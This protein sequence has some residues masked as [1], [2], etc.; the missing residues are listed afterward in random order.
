MKRYVKLIISCILAVVLM[1]NLTACTGFFTNPISL[2]QPPKLSGNLV[3][4]ENTLSSI[5]PDYQL[6][7]PTSGKFRNAII[8]R[9]L[10]KDGKEEAIVFYQ[11]TENQTINVHMNILSY[12]ADEWASEYDTVLAGA[13]IER[14]EFKDVCFDDGEEIL[15]GSKLYNIQENQ[16]NV[17]SYESGKVTLLSEEIY[18]E[19]CVGNIGASK[20]PQI[21]LFKIASRAQTASSEIKDSPVKKTVS[22]KLLSFSY[23]EDGAPVSLG[24]VEFDANTISFSSIQVGLIKENQKGIFVD[25]FIGTNAM[26]T[27]VL[28]YDETLKTSFYHQKA[29]STDATYRESLI[30][31]VDIDKD[32]FIEIPKTYI[33]QGYET[34][35]DESQ[36]VY[37][38][39]WYSVDGKNLGERKLSGFINTADSYFLKTPATWLGVITAQRVLENRERIFYEWDV[40]NRTYGEELFRIRVFLKSD[41]AKNSRN[42]IKVNSDNDYVYAVKINEN[43]VSENKVTVDELKENIILL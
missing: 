40:N 38:T 18:T 7:Y 10:N 2:M 36:R 16:L 9:D 32:G 22:A 24:T 27:E 8:L 17:F 31:C 43:A 28:Y 29:N 15:V 11:T 4:I 37:F 35:T 41:F 5:Y 12:L 14:V 30:G 23:S 42:Y 26:I 25:A 6:S 20:K 19:Y 34:A 13:G 1:F 39:E 3:E 33:C 21:A